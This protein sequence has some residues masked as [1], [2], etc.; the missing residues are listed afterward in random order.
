M[1]LQIQVRS[2]T[3]RSDTMVRKG[4]GAWFQAK[5]IP[6]LFSQKQWLVALLLS[7]LIG[8]LGVDRMYIGQVGLGIIKLIT[9]GG[10]GIWYIIDI[11]LFA[12]DKVADSRGL[13]L[14][15]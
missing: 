3:V 11:V 7:I 12:T 9:C 14:S 2:G 15:R 6:G 10:L 13:P 4:D 5:E 1:D 8:S